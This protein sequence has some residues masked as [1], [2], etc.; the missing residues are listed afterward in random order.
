MTRVLIEGLPAWKNGAG[1]LFF[2]D[3]DL[4]KPPF[5]IGTI[6]GGFADDWVSRLQERLAE[7]RALAVPRVRATKKIER[8]TTPSGK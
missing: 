3:Q 7:Y 6:E 5:Q 4:S 8:G 1:E 2:Y